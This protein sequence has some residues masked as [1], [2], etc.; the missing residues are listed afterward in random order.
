MSEKYFPEFQYLFSQKERL[1]IINVHAREVVSHMIK[2]DAKLKRDFEWQKNIKFYWE[3]DI[4]V[5]TG[6][7]RMEVVIK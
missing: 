3:K 5:Q 4:N 6:E 7:E 2:K 1:I